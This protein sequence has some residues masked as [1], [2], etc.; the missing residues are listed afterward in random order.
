MHRNLAENQ[1]SLRQ[2][3][4]IGG[5]FNSIGK[6]LQP[7]K[8][9]ASFPKFAGIHTKTRA[10]YLNSFFG[11]QKITQKKGPI[12]KSPVSK[13]TPPRGSPTI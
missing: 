6:D 9:D 5:G 1:Q 10:S 12:L 2:V 13:D 7:S 11:H 4:T 3:L 8:L